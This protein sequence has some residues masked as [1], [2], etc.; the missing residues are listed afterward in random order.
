[1]TANENEEFILGEDVTGQAKS[2]SRGGTAVIAVRLSLEE[3]AQVESISRETGR[4]VSHVVR[5]AIRNWLRFEVSGQPTVTVTY[6]GGPTTT[7]GTLG[8]QGHAKVVEGH[9]LVWDVEKVA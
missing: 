2:K 6:E 4:T 3:L 9:N 1:M 8:T 7:V 5:E